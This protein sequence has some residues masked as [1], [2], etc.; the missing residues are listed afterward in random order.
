M[1]MAVAHLLI[2]NRLQIDEPE[3]PGLSIDIYGGG[4]GHCLVACLTYLEN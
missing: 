4:A 2:G 1:V 3:S